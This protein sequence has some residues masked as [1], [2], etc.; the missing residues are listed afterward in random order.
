MCVS[1]NIHDLT[2]K[3]LDSSFLKCTIIGYLKLVFSASLHQ[4]IL[5]LCNKVVLVKT[6]S[7]IAS[8]P[9]FC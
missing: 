5:L 2:H 9:R 4:K 3:I 8:L 1:S 7:I 6:I